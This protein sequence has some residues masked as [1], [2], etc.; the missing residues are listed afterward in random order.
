MN[1]TPGFIMVL[2]TFG[3]DLKWNP[4]VHCLISEGGYSDN[5]L[6]RNISYFNYTFL[7]NAFRTALFNEME[8]MTGPSFKKIKSRCYREHKEV[9]TY[10]QSPTNATPR[11]PS[12]ILATISGGL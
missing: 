9:S 4:H 6:W 10:M 3:R 1:F 7:R 5:G 11:Q 2:H 8:A 12:D